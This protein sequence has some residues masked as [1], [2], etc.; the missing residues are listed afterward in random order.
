MNSGNHGPR[1]GAR[2][3]AATSL[4]SLLAIF[5]SLPSSAAEAPDL[6]W[7]DVERVIDAATMYHYQAEVQRETVESACFFDPE[8][9]NTMGC[10]WIWGTGGSDPYL[11]EQRA[12]RRATK[13]CK[14]AGASKCI[15]FWR[16]G[17]IRFDGLASVQSQ[18]LESALAKIPEFEVEASSLPEGFGVSDQFREWFPTARDFWEEIRKKNRGRNLH[19][20]ICT[21]EMGQS[22]SFHMQGPGTHVSVV[23]DLCVLK[24]NA[25]AGYYSTGAR[26]H[27]VYQNGEFASA[28][29]ERATMR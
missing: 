19:Y 28:A 4:P 3:Y 7:R 24:C 21:S 8:V 15:L 9:E 17:R 2:R 11:L 14:E 22:A 13:W 20:A 23:R 26:C 10:S 12:K 16:N 18:R 29:A 5:L 6:K 1:T 25:L 27:V